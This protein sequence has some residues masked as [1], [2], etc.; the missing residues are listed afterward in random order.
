[1]DEFW[2]WMKKKQYGFKGNNVQIAGFIVSF[3][4]QMLIGY[5]IEYLF[6]LGIAD[7][8]DVFSECTTDDINEIYEYLT[9]DINEIVN[10]KI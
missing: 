3:T 1:M 9:D 7:A 10:S 4:K 8:F 6:Y 2:K 5:M